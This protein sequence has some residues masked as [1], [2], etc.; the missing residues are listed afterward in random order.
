[1]EEAFN[2]YQ[3]W[4]AL[5]ATLAEPSHYELLELDADEQDPSVIRLAADRALAR[6]RSS[7]PGTRA[8]AWTQLLDR[9]A[10]AKKCLADSSL[11]AA[12]DQQL[13]IGG[14]VPIP[15]QPVAMH[16]DP[17]AVLTF[18]ALPESAELPEPSG[19]VNAARSSASPEAD[20]DDPE[21]LRVTAESNTFE[22]P[23][24]AADLTLTVRRPTHRAE[25][26]A[27][28]RSRSRATP[29]WLAMGA[30]FG[31]LAG[32]AG[33]FAFR[34]GGVVPDNELAA[35]AAAPDSSRDDPTPRSPRKRPRSGPR[36]DPVEIR[37]EPDDES[38]FNDPAEA[39]PPM[40]P[41]TDLTSPSTPSTMTP[42]PSAPPASMPPTTD[43]PGGERPEYREELSRLIR[44]ARQA[45]AERD[46]RL[47]DERITEANRLARPEHEGRVQRMALLANAVQQFWNG[48]EESLKG[49]PGLAEFSY[50]NSVAVVREKPGKTFEFRH[51]GKNHEIPIDDLPP[52]L[53]RAVAAAWFD[54][55]IGTNLM[56]RGAFEASQEPLTDAHRDRA[57]ELWRQARAAGTD[58]GDL[59]QILDDDAVQR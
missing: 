17:R 26:A 9:I 7:R 3:H 16:Q 12:Y 18:Q 6:V 10:E 27:R 14:T 39:E 11:R 56:L 21:K 34:G 30:V 57:R 22:E 15:T 42:S 20:H 31:M 59:P 28:E 55:K 53:A 44:E 19:P 25:V 49:V 32:A 50:R 33:W 45:L 41:T 54:P 52:D 40:P 36:Q 35:N 51:E 23:Q 4:L 5:P 43:D 8:V 58:M 37:A 46:F 1:M 38:D 47:A 13:R 2:P 48:V 29:L 24:S